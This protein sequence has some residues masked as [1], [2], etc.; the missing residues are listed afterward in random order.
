MVQVGS[1][2]AASTVLVYCRDSIL[3]GTRLMLLRSAGY[4]ALGADTLQ[5]AAQILLH[6]HMDVLILCH[7]ISESDC[8]RA[9]AL[10]V[11]KTTK[12]LILN[13]GTYGCG[14]KLRDEFS[15]L[16]PL[17]ASDGPVQLLS[18]V[19]RLVHSKSGVSC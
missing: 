11:S 7:T 9:L 5:N 6:E 17:D 3:L 12:V 2:S 8:R 4:R 15:F 18:T 14:F 19:D 13:A 16:E 1:S 10:P